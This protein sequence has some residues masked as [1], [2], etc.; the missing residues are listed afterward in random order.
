MVKRSVRSVP[1]LILSLLAALLW[2]AAPAVAATSSGGVVDDRA[3]I[4][5][6]AELERLENDLTGRRFGFRVIILEE[7][8]AGAEPVDAEA[9]FQ[10]MADELLAEVP[11][12]AVLITIAMEEGLVDFRVWRDGAVQSAFREATG[13]A[14]ERSVEQIMDAFVPPAAEGDIA[15]AIVA[16]A[17][18][19]ESLAAAPAAQPS[20]ATGGSGA[21]RPSPGPGGSGVAQPGAGGA[22]ARTSAPGRIGAVL[23]GLAALIAA[24]V[25]LALFLQYRRTHRKCLELRNSFV[26]DLVKMHEQDLPLARNYD[27]EETRGHVTAAAA[28]SDRAFDAYRA[29]SEK[30]AEA[31]RL[32]RRW[33]FGAG[34]RALDEVYRAFQQAAAANREAQEAYAPVSAAILGWDGAVG[35]TGARR[36]AAERTLADLQDQTGWEFPALR[37]RMD[38]AARLQQAAEAARGKDPVRALRIM[39]EAGETFAAIGADL[40]RLSGLREAC[41]AQR[42]DADQARAEIEQARVGL[43]LRFVEEDPVQALERALQDQARAGERMARGDVDG[44]EQAL[45]GGQAALDEARAI[46]ARYREAVEQYPGKRQALVEG[47]GW[48]AAQQGPAR[49]VLDQLAARYAPEDWADVR[50]LPAALADLERRAQADLTEAERLVRPEVQRHLQAYRLLNERLA[51]LAALRE[52]AALL[53]TLPDRLA[54]A[55]EAAR[56]KLTRAEREWAAARELVSREGLALPRDAAERADRIEVALDRARRLLEERPLA[57]GRAGR[58]AAAALEL[59]AGL[60]Q[61]VAE[62]ARRAGEARARLRQARAQATAA[63]VHSRF[64]PGAAAALQR[65][66]DAGEQAMAAGR[67]DQAVAEAES[68]LRSARALVAAY[69]RHKAEERRRQMAMA[70]AA[71]QAMRRASEPRGHFRPGPG[72][73]GSGG[74]GGFGGGPRGSGG[75]GRFGGGGRG[76]G[77]GGRWK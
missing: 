31:A 56:E 10:A 49:N 4:F 22:A 63:L 45:A 33:R 40:T 53:T 14:F 52:R 25:E 1:A 46:L 28:A 58:E 67:Y 62:L 59:A 57:V 76:S 51:E 44:A 35:E 50:D 20:P 18:R 17:N 23:A 16:A 38:A 30:L 55:G 73:R 2:V 54:A 43:G 47:A 37:E 12:D 19:I 74:G 61:A 48:L 39:R 75:G 34:T 42:R 64:N 41:A 69:Q 24:V 7:A 29:G 65:A 13:R 3:G 68:A 66:L 32:A 70:A 21:G 77:G 26:S 27:G 71:A 15:G 5:S 6:A 8:F 9:R 60:R 36:E 11:R 72:G